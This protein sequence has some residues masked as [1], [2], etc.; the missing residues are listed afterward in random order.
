MNR[1]RPLFT[2]TRRI[3]P[4]AQALG[5][6]LATQDYAVMGFLGYVSVLSWTVPTSAD[7]N[8]ARS[9][10]TC[11]FAAAA[12][13]LIA[14]R[15]ELLERAP[16]RA[17]VYRAGLFLSMAGT[18]FLVGWLN[19]A[20][21]RVLD[22][23]LYAI[24]LA[25]LGVTPAVWLQQFNEPHI[26]EWFAFFYWSYFPLMALVL[27]PS[28]LAG[29]G[30]VHAQLFAGVLT[31]AALGHIGYTLVPGYGP[32]RFLSW[33]EPVNGGF[34]W[35]QVCATVFSGGA[36]MDIFP[37]LHTAY[38]MFFA[39]WAFGNRRETPWLRY[40]WPVMAFV[41]ANIIVATMLLRWHWGIDIIFGVLLAVT[42][43]QVSIYLTQRE[44]TREAEGRQPLWEPVFRPGR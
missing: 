28:L 25:L 43:R 6:N 38:P 30:R 42:A 10:S 15:G 27:L 22:G 41:S 11:L 12:A 29:K 17:L 37:S 4:L 44:S 5:R 18:Y 1:H 26:I 8:I 39:L 3:E 9:L 2:G 32:Y 24:D 16:V 21:G 34:W 13:A 40:T 33:S 20:Q 14:T 35:E 31:I 23:P 7:A 19:P 36:M